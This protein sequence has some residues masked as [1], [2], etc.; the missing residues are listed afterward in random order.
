MIAIVAP[1]GGIAAVPMDR[2]ANWKRGRHSVEQEQIH[3]V[4]RSEEELLYAHCFLV[5]ITRTEL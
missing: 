1:N 5:G 3:K 4:G 2:T